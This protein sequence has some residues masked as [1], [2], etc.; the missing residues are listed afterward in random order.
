MR[1]AA[2]SAAGVT[3]VAALLLL[4]PAAPAFAA[5]GE[6]ISTYDTRLAVGAD[7]SMRVTET[8]AYDFGGGAKHGIFRN[9]PVKAH[10]DD[11]RD[12]VY[13]ISAVTVTRDGAA[14]PVQQDSD[15]NDEVLKIGDPDNGNLTGTH[16][17]VIGY[18][19]RGAVNTFSDHDELY[20][21]AIGSGWS[22]P[23][24]AGTAEITGPADVQRVAC[25]GGPSSGRTPCRQATK[26]GRSAAFAESGLG[27]GRNLTVVVAFP[28]GSVANPGPILR[29]R[30][31][32]ARAF[33]PT[34][35]NLGG[36]AAAALGGTGLALLAAYRLGRDRRYVG[37]L[38]GLTPGY[39]E[40]A[41]EERKPLLGRPPDVVEFGVP[42]GLRPGQVGTLQDEKADVVDVTAT[43]V[44][45]AVRRHLLIRELGTGKDWEL[46]K[47]TDP[48][49]DFLPYEKVLFEALFHGR[50][51]VRLA[52]LKQ[53]FA[54]DLA[55]VRSELYQDMVAQGWYKRSPR[56]TRVR[57]AWVAAGILLLSVG[58]TV[59]L[60]AAF[61][62]G[63]IGVGLVVA[64]IVLLC[65]S[66]RFPARTGKGSAAL[67]RL[68]GLRLYIQSAEAEQIRFQEREQIFS[69]LLPYAIVF[70]LADRW[71]GVFARI[72]AFQ[73]SA[74]SPT[75]LYW[76]AASP[77]WTFGSFNQSITG[78]TATTATSLSTTPA[79][80]ASGGSGFSGGFSGGGGGGGGGGSW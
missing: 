51:K 45:F 23:I 49:S 60:A 72:G 63:W 70:G 56:A 58:L 17:Y 20:W 75:G 31:D 54:G 27:S 28:K 55:R 76:Y 40:R 8:I 61:G 22:V 5:P 41:D 59:L 77:G 32:A 7:G 73:P 48:P 29:P 1:A 42:D 78:F 25:F 24:A 21:N 52:R 65:L 37:Q 67:S 15:G 26:N 33:R 69:G 44:D 53:T 39:G 12:R 68:R 62:L 10:A 30:H 2:I 3:G 80:A 35:L 16:T 64:S 18:T 14:E 13:P 34:A 74:A 6:S 71:A 19:V 57:A 4:G 9:I 43:I 36:G 38:P 46:V 47:L 50:D 11:D 66:G 79:S